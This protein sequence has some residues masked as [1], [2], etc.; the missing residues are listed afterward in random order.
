M[1]KQLSRKEKIPVQAAF[2]KSEN[3][4]IQEVHLGK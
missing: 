4:D 3:I 2:K 1:K